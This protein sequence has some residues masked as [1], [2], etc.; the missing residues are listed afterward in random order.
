[1]IARSLGNNLLCGLDEDGEGTYTAE[2]IVA[3]VEMLKVNTTLQS[4]RCVIRVRLLSQASAAF[5]ASIR[6]SFAVLMA[7]LSKS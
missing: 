4:I 3:I 6:L 5:D 7:T 2:G 1:M